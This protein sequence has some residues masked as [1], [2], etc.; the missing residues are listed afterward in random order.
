MPNRFNTARSSV[1]VTLVAGAFSTV[2]AAQ[3]PDHYDWDGPYPFGLTESE[4]DTII[5]HFYP[6]FHTGPASSLTVAERRFVKWQLTGPDFQCWKYDSLCEGF[7]PGRAGQFLG[8]YVALLRRLPTATDYEE[9]HAALLSYYEDLATSSDEYFMS[10]SENALYVGA[11]QHFFGYGTSLMFALPDRAHDG[12]GVAASVGRARYIIAGHSWA[13]AV[14]VP[15]NGTNVTV[16]GTFRHQVPTLAG[17]QWTANTVRTKTKSNKAVVTG[18]ARSWIVNGFTP[19]LEFFVSSDAS[20][21]FDS[22][23]ASTTGFFN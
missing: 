21:A 1:F 12:G 9:S 22:D 19:S 18:T 10:T 8:D 14:A 7:G 16:L 3:D 23:F 17:P 5:D 13:K 4:I 15:K 6:M 2:A 20:S 11:Y